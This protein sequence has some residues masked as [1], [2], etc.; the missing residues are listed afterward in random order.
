ML[1]CKSERH[2]FCY[3][4][5]QRPDVH[6]CNKGHI[7]YYFLWDR[8]METKTTEYENDKFVEDNGIV[9]FSDQFLFAQEASGMKME[10]LNILSIAEKSA[11]PPYFSAMV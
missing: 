7:N 8:R 4:I 10:T 3:K 6:F 9:L 2:V 11:R 1:N 5:G